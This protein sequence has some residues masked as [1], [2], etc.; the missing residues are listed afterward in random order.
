MQFAL[1]NK[2]P[3]SLARTATSGN[4]RSSNAKYF[5]GELARLKVDTFDQIFTTERD[6]PLIVRFFWLVVFLFSA[7]A[8]VFLVA[9][10]VQEYA[11]YEV[12]TT[13]RV[14][15][16][17]KAD[18][19]AITFCSINPFSSPYADEL[20]ASTGNISNKGINR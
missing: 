19:P 8:C 5:R 7:S 20:F 16:E 2:A 14:V 6:E 3:F 1:E 11:K 13:I 9:K 18:F 15:T 4:Q 17:Q 12:T 10:S